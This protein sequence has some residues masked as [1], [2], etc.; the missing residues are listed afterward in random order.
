MTEARRFQRPE[1]RFLVSEGADV[2]SW[3]QGQATNDVAVPPGQSVAFC[4]VSPTGQLEA[5]VDGRRTESGFLFVTERPEALLARVR[6]FVILED[7][8]LRLIEGGVV[9]VTGEPCATE[10][11]IPVPGGCDI[12]GDDG[13]PEDDLLADR[14]ARGIPDPL[15]DA[16]DRTLPPEL[17]TWFDRRY[18]HYA[19]GCYTGQEVLQRIYSRGHVNRLWAAFRAGELVPVATPVHDEAGERVGAVT[20]CR[21][22]AQLGPVVGA[23]VKRGA[24][25]DKLSCGNVPLWPIPATLDGAF[26]P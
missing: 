7:V 16:T 5:V 4:L 21:L 19:K 17:G 25:L 13:E 20:Q 10:W 14:L 12:P 9:T 26:A 22:H 1:R 3:W 8:S 24:N 6:D 2:V 18:V 11:A 23:Y 15:R